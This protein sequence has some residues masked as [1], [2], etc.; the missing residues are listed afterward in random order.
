[1]LPHFRMLLVCLAY[2]KHIFLF[3]AILQL[4]GH[5]ST[6]ALEESQFNYFFW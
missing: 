1:M 5:A 2:L 4:L 6:S 3:W